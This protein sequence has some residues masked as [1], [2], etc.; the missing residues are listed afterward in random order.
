MQKACS[1]L[2]YNSYVTDC[3][4]PVSCLKA[5]SY[6]VQNCNFIHCFPWV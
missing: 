3:P 2:L 1:F 5:W 6:Y 4:N